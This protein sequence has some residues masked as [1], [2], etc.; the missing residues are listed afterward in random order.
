MTDPTI[1]GAAISGVVSLLSAYL[2]YR[3]GIRQAEQQAAPEKPDDTT[4]VQG[5]HALELV[6]AGVD[7]HGDADEHADLASFRRNPQ[8]Y[9]ETL[10]KVLTDI[11]RREPAF[12]QQLQTFAQQAAIQASGV[13]GTVNNPGTITGNAAGVNTGTMTYNARDEGKNKA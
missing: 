9:Q 2:T 6:I 12:A 1:I 10:A 8:R 4:L 5:Q 7:R 3:L 13:H 11:A